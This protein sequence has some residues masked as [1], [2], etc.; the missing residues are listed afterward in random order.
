MRPGSAIVGLL[1]AAFVVN[2][3]NGV[4]SLVAVKHTKVKRILGGA[5]P[6]ASPLLDHTKREKYIPSRSC[7][8][9][10]LLALRGSDSL[11]KEKKGL[12]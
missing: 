7:E 9:S 3:T 12:I 6:G 1:D 8:T 4:G 2:S 11:F 10:F 5:P